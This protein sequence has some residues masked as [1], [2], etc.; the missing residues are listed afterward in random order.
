[1][2]IEPEIVT[3]AKIALSY[4]TAAGVGVFGAKLAW[5]SLR[6]RGLPSVLGRSALTTALVFSFF[7]V[8][9]H[10][11]VGVSEVHF[12]LGSTLFLLFGAA[13]AAIGLALGLLI[14]GLFFTPFDLPQYGMNVTTL[15]VPLFALQALA[16]R[17]IAPG[18]A[19]VDLGYG[20]ALAL[21]TA[22]Q[23]GVVAWVAFWAIYGQGFA[24]ISG[25]ATFGAAYMLVVLIE[26]LVDLAVLAGAKSLRGLRDSGLVTSRLFA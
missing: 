13:P 20:Q 5:Q 17:I 26:P 1:M 25:I 24:G 19:Y 18:T 15:L 23:G 6:E 16:R 9:P 12:I 8:L 7:Q 11:P 22:Y 2:H 4:A 3:G 14:Q 21:S 10:F